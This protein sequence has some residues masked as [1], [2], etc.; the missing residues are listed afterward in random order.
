MRE[1]VESIT[2]LALF[3]LSNALAALLLRAVGIATDFVFA[4]FLS[5]FVAG[6]NAT[7]LLWTVDCVEDRGSLFPCAL[8]L[9]TI[10]GL[11]SLYALPKLLPPIRLEDIPWEIVAKASTAGAVVA[12][13]ALAAVR[14]SF[15]YALYAIALLSMLIFAAILS[16]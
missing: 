3:A 7:F 5:I 14:R 10:P 11:I 9:F 6:V 2:L 8:L 13:T 15:D 12:L 4:L 1:E 16:L